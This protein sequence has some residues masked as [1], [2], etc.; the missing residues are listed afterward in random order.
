MK[1][2]T[3][4]PTAAPKSRKPKAATAKPSRPTPPPANVLE[5]PPAA[6]RPRRLAPAAPRTR[7]APTLPV[8]AVALRAYQLFEARHSAHGHDL[9]DWFQ[10]EAELAA[11]VKATKRRKASA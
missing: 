9:E 10:A 2:T 1:R 11:E 6:T 3:P 4:T 8:D 7:T 5:M